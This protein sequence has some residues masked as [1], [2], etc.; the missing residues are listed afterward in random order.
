MWLSLIGKAAFRHIMALKSCKVVNSL[1]GN[2][3]TFVELGI[4]SV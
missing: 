2:M 3:E 4:N 1:S